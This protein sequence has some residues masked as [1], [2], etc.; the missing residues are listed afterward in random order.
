MKKLFFLLLLL[1]FTLQAQVAEPEVLWNAEDMYGYCIKQFA[2][3]Q[4]DAAILAKATMKAGSK[5]IYVLN[6]PYFKNMP[7][8]VAGFTIKYVDMD[9][10]AA[11]LYNEQTKK[12]AAILYLA[13][14]TGSFDFYRLY[15]FP[16]TAGKKGLSYSDKFC[17]FLY[18]FHSGKQQFELR[19]TKYVDPAK[20]DEKI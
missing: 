13:K 11:M 1:P 7:D 5:V 6:E 20:G 12:G 4:G 15:L 10:D 18:E 9:K 16:V 2:R 14:F 19:K 17:E 3:Q 8:T